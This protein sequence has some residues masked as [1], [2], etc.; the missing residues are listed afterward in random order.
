[1]PFQVYSIDSHNIQR[2]PSV[3][4]ARTAYGYKIPAP[5]CRSVK[6]KIYNIIQEKSLCGCVH[7][8]YVFIWFL[9]SPFRWVHWWRRRMLITTSISP[10]AL[11]DPITCMGV[12]SYR[13]SR[14]YARLKAEQPLYGD[15]TSM[16]APSAG[17]KNTLLPGMACIF[18]LRPYKSTSNAAK[19]VTQ[20]ISFS[21]IL[22]LASFTKRD[23]AQTIQTP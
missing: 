2:L 8:P 15:G 20:R 10:T 7:M 13:E 9:Q 3:E 1:V 21:S 23:N 6:K 11:P 17:C 5:I 12:K 22:T 16:C 19:L 18:Y 14:F 4:H